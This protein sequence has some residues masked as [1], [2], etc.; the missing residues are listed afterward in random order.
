MPQ[1]FTFFQDQEGKRNQ[2]HML[3]D[4]KTEF[5]VVNLD[6]TEFFAIKKSQNF[7]K[8]ILTRLNAVTHLFHH[9]TAK[10]D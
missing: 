4:E 5:F 3:A 8:D 6:A 1:E 10:A 7:S 2:K 9:P